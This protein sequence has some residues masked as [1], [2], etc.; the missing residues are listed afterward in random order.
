M[1]VVIDIDEQAGSP[2]PLVL[3]RATELQRLLFT[4][5]D[6]FLAIASTYQ[7]E[8]KFFAGIIYAPQPIVSIGDCVRDLELIAK[9]CAPADLSNYVQYL[10]L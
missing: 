3:Q 6:D 5:D 9:A 8:G 1:R 4:R 10:P 2:E 7:Q